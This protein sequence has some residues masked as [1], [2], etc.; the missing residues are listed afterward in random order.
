M[1]P[2]TP[3]IATRALTVVHLD[4][5]VASVEVSIG[6][7]RQLSES[8]WCCAIALKGMLQT[9]K[10]VHGVDS[11]Q[12]LMLAQSLARQLLSYFIDDGGRILVEPEGASIDVDNLF[13]GG[14]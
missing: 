3:Y 4:G 7:P 6:A 14:G 11:F 10:D 2:Q 5:R 13:R 9:P 12:A 1:L 8:E